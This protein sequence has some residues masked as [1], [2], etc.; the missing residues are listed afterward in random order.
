MFDDLPFKSYLEY[1]LIQVG[2]IDITIG[3]I[4]I[5][6]VAIV[7]TKC[8]L[9]L[10]RY[11]IFK[12]SKFLSMDRGSLNS[13]FKIISYLIWVISFTLTLEAIGISVSVLIAGSAALMV[14]VG[15]GLQQTFNDIVSGII[16]LTERTIKRYDVLEVDGNVVRIQEIGLRTS[17]AVDRDGISIIIPNS[18]ITTNKVVNWSHQTLNT[19]FKVNV[20]VAYGSDVD[21]VMQL[22]NEA[23]KAHPAITAPDL[24]FTRFIDFGSSS[25]D[26]KVYFTC[27]KIFEIEGIK[28]DIRVAILKNFTEHNIQIPFPQMDLH[29]KNLPPA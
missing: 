2:S 14:G 22:T 18:L 21:L 1:H 15:L 13:I 16:L 20:G 17:K 19:Q 29:V 23:A 11:L 4:V 24:V 26:F 5:V 12:D 3:A 27:D 10:L 6:L 9:W 28:S 25:L 8:F 7:L